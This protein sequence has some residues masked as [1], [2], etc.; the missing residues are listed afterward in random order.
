MTTARALAGCAIAAALM[1]ISSP[2]P[3]DTTRASTGQS[4]RF[5]STRAGVGLETP[6]GW[7]LSQHTGYPNVLCILIHPGGSRISVAVDRA[8]AKDSAAL[9]DENRPGL[10]AQ[11]LTID[12]VSSGPLGGLLVDARAPHRDQS[13]RQLYLVR[14]LTVGPDPRQ[15]VILTLTTTREQLAAAS[16]ALDWVIAH[17]DLRA[18]VRPDDKS[19]KPDGGI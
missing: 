17:L 14:D 5:L 2:A 9:V 18:P 13:L 19:E 8:T 6:P 16:S 7:S 4:G 10:V 15:A 1:A 12:R 3:A 11:G